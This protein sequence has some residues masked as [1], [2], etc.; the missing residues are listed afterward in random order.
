MMRASS[1]FLRVYQIM[2]KKKNDKII[3]FLG[4]DTDFEGT[5][6]FKGSMRIDGH[7]KGE[8]FAT[9]TLYVGESGVIESKIHATDIVVCGE[10]RGNLA[11]DRKIEIQVPGKVFGNIK[12][13][14]V[15][16]QEGVI[17]EGNCRTVKA[18]EDTGLLKVVSP[19]GGGK[20]GKLNPVEVEAK[21]S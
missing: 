12:A 21:V 11:A 10:V 4:K 6:K 5:L 13:P 7:F 14:T 18:T 17:F 1:N 2:S 3:A 9:G 20:K 16:L 15:I 19:E 8:I